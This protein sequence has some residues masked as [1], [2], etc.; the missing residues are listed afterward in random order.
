MS[1]DD[2]RA[3]SRAARQYNQ[4]NGT[5]VIDCK[6]LVMIAA[7]NKQMQIRLEH[8]MQAAADA[9]RKRRREVLQDASDHDDEVV[10]GAPPTIQAPELSGNEDCG[11][12]EIE[13]F[14]SLGM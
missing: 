4:H 11:E 14:E 2:V 6:A 1:P 7:G 10:V 8:G 9:C 5:D 13:F 12:D 3:A